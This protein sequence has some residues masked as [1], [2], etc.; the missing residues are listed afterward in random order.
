MN[1]CYRYDLAH[2]GACWYDEDGNLVIAVGFA[3]PNE[4]QIRLE[5]RLR[6]GDVAT[7]SRRIPLETA[8][9]IAEVVTRLI[10]LHDGGQND[11]DSG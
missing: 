8:R 10:N 4:V 11:G 9:E 7:V 3:W 5:V 6:E 1:L 2:G